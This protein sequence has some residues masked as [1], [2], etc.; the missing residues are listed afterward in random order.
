M[1]IGWHLCSHPLGQV[2]TAEQPNPRPMY[3]HHFLG[4]DGQPI[5]G[6]VFASDGIALAH[7]APIAGFPPCC[8]RCMIAVELGVAKVSGQEARHGG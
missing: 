8:A 3:G 2:P 7:D 5:C 6:E 1:K 4:T